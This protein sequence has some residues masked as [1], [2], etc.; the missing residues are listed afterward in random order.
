MTKKWDKVYSKAATLYLAM[1]QFV[2]GELGAPNRWSYYAPY[3]AYEEIEKDI[4]ELRKL[5]EKKGKTYR[6]FAEQ[7]KIDIEDLAKARQTSDKQ[8]LVTLKEQ[9]SVRAREYERRTFAKK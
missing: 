4:V 1:S 7:L 2:D 8:L 3:P 5:L 6:L 9:F